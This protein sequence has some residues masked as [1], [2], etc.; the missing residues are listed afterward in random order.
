MQFTTEIKKERYKS[1]PMRIYSRGNNCRE[2][3]FGN[4]FD[5]FYI[6]SI[7]QFLKNH[8]DSI[9]FKNNL[10]ENSTIILGRRTIYISVAVSFRKKTYITYF[11]SW[12]I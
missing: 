4:S 10:M 8:S 7:N 12:I 9:C 3:N 2:T 1:S 11:C 6:A 5:F